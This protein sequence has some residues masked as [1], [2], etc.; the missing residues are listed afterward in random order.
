[1]LDLPTDRPRAS[2]Q[3]TDVSKIPIHLDAQLT[4]SLKQVAI[5]YDMDLSMVVIASWSAVLARLSSEDDII[6]GYHDSSQ[7]GPRSN[8]QADKDCIWPLRLDLSCEPNIS[9]LFERV[10]TMN[11]TSMGHRGLP[12]NG[13][14]EIDSSPLIQVAFRWNNQTSSHS[15]APIQFELELQLQEQD[16][17]L[18]GGMLYSSDLFNPD[19][20]ER[21]IGYLVTML[22]AITADVNRPVSSVDLLSQV[23]RDLVLGKWN[24]TFQDY[25]A[26]LCIHH[27]FEQQVEYTPQAT[28]LVFNSQ[29]M[30]YSELNERANRIAHR[31]IGLGVQPDSFVAICIGRSFAMIVAVFAVLKAGGAY[32]PLDPT[33]P[34]SRL[35]DILTDAA[36][37]IVIADESGRGVLGESVLASLAVV[38][39]GS[40][41]A[42]D[43]SQR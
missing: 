42:L 22:Q 20:I 31:L 33:Y 14:A 29:S 27:L 23:E 15:P 19:T 3:S 4:L 2:R 32:V 18:V 21:H 12:L 39:P 30:S 38:D 24:E 35:R 5:E 9:Q 11:S 40:G 28:A 1:M 10:R 26:N 13:I 6:I 17:E 7:G 41:V 34:S 8:Q 36:P 25:P 16:N 37:R 43:K